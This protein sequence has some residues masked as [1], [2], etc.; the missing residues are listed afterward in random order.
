M[1]LNK[2]TSL[3][4]TLGMAAILTGCG[5]SSSSSDDMDQLPGGNTYQ[6]VSYPFNESVFVYGSPTKWN[7]NSNRG[8]G[9]ATQDISANPG[10]FTVR[11][12]Q[13]STGTQEF[14]VAGYNFDSVNGVNFGGP[15]GGTTAVTLGTSYTMSGGE[16][17]GNL[18][19]MP[20]NS[21]RYYY[22]FNVDFSSSANTP[23]VL[24]TKATSPF[25]GLAMFLR[26][27][28]PGWDSNVSQDYAFQAT[29]EDKYVLHF[30]TNSSGVTEFKVAATPWNDAANFGTFAD[31]ASTLTLGTALD[32]NNHGGSGNIKLDLGSST[33]T[34]R[35]LMIFD[36]SS[37]DSPTLTVTQDTAPLGNINLAL[38][39]SH[40]AWQYNTDYQLNYIG[41][42]TY[43]GEMT[44][45]GNIEFKV[46]DNST[47]WDNQFWV[48]AE[49]YPTANNANGM[50]IDPD[51][52]APL[53]V[54]ATYNIVRNNGGEGNNALNGLSGTYCVTMK[55]SRPIS[56][57]LNVRDAAV[58]YAGTL[59]IASGNC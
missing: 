58:P 55:L 6:Q 23:T 34:K 44:L 41:S 50:D 46:A 30:E 33:D 18:S 5:S 27:S 42:D 47:S 38:R 49:G 19:F 11:L 21:H 4:A 2:Y 8:V 48:P 9:L 28:I 45:T 32:L 59:R 39:G 24:V 37:V 12:P 7:S 57:Q 40:S 14:K 29:G 10:V 51:K 56:E 15:E 20:D 16:N 43:Q 54:G 22:D 17:P 53:S 26:G 1:K 36:Y 35:Y 52:D 13:S 25:S 31:G 3:A